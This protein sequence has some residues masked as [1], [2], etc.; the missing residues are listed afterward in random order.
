MFERWLRKYADGTEPSYA[1]KK[2]C[3][4]ILF[5]LPVGPEHVSK[6]QSLLTLIQKHQSC[7]HKDLKQLA[8]SL[9]FKWDCMLADN[10]DDEE[11]D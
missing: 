6:C 8:E 1:L 2:G 3:F 9:T 4:E 11:R 7:N 10:Y 5:S